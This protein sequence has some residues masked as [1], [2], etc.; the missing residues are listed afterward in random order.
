MSARIGTMYVGGA[1]HYV[2]P[3]SGQKAPG[4]TSVLSLLP[5]PFLPA[6]TSKV[7]AEWAVDNLASVTDIASRDRQAAVDIIKGA[8]KRSTTGSADAG[9]E[10]HEYLEARLLGN[11][12]RPLSA[13]AQEFAPAIEAFLDEWKPEPVLLEQS[14]WG[15]CAEGVYAGSFDGILNIAGEKGILVDFKSGKSCYPEASIQLACYRYASELIGGGSIPEI[16]GAAV[17]HVRP[18]GVK[19]YPTAATRDKLEVFEACYRLFKWEQTK[20][21]ALGKA[22]QVP[23]ADG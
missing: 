13:R 14:V 16:T 5:K 11:K 2:H 15:E 4:V 8:S 20:N 3:K 17:I 23:K 6:W 10:V 12:P 7:A 19:V 21:A 1:R 22:L 18:E 9:T